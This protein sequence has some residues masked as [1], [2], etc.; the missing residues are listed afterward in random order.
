MMEKTLKDEQILFLLRFISY[1]NV[2][3]RRLRGILFLSNNTVLSAGDYVIYKVY[4]HR[5]RKKIGR[6]AVVC[7]FFLLITKTYAGIR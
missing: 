7:K 3:L 6:I 4:L 1:A 2:L 5:L